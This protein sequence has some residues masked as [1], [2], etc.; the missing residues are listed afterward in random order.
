[1]KIHIL[2]LIILLMFISI[3]SESYAQNR[4][5]LCLTFDDGNPNDILNYKAEVW[6]QMILDQLKYYDLQAAFYVRGSGMDNEKGHEILKLWNNAGHIL[7]NHTYNHRNFNDRN[8]S[9][10]EYLLDIQ[11]NDSLLSRYPGYF[12]IF[13]APFLKYGETRDKRDSLNSY[14]KKNE[15]LNG[16]VTIDASDWYYNSELIK[17]LRKN[18]KTNIDEFREL[19]IE[20]LLDRAEYYDDLAYEILGRRIKHSLLLHHNLTSALFLG[21]LI[22]AFKD[23]GWDVI[24]A[25]YVF[26]D[27]IYRKIPDIVP[28]GESIIWGLA[29]ETGKYENKLRYP[30]EDSRYEVDKL[31]SLGL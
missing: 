13:R 15:Y 29:K 20:H 8:I 5:T 22:E 10:E 24:H 6:N 31:N 9:A 26:A 12:R 3:C 21:D 23:N 28:A 25:G 19:Y 18:P 30:G 27:E 7:A 17:L 11:K 14:L 4:P 1:M 2:S 16:Y